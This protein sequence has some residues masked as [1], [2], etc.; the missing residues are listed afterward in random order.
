MPVAERQEEAAEPKPVAGRK[1]WAEVR[2]AGR[3]KPRLARGCRTS[4]KI[5][6]ELRHH[7]WNKTPF[8]SSS[9]TQMYSIAAGRA[10][11]G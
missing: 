5:F 9:V 2:G 11:Q 1:R 7:S 10:M 4:R 6:L 3:T 8:G